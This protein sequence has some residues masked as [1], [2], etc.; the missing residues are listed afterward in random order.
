MSIS[1]L[2]FLSH[3]HF[4][5]NFGPCAPG[6]SPV[7]PP[8]GRFSTPAGVA[9][10]LRTLLSYPNVSPRGGL[11]IMPLPLSAPPGPS[12]PLSGRRRQATGAP[13][14]G[15]TARPPAEARFRVAGALPHRPPGATEP[16]RGLVRRTKPR[17]PVTT[18]MALAGCHWRMVRPPAECGQSAP[19]RPRHASDR[20]LRIAL[21]ATHG[22]WV[23]GS[24]AAA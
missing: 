13:R 4:K 2:S 14:A 20:V 19:Q 11:G 12:R 22:G 8:S 24:S 3:G 7:R 23:C 18:R 1:I 16:A 10:N 6:S 15:R 21:S 5:F 17:L 9:R